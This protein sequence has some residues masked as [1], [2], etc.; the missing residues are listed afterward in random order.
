MRTTERSMRGGASSPRG[1][2]PDCSP[3]GGGLTGWGSAVAGGLSADRL[4]KENR[5]RRRRLA[6]RKV[7]TRI[8]PTLAHAILLRHAVMRHRALL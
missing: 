7:W 4:G 6:S 1:A 3:G 2:L 5:Q 8:A